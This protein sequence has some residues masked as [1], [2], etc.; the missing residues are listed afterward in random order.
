MSEKSA[1]PVDDNDRGTQNSNS[2]IDSVG[3]CIVCGQ[4]YVRRELST[5]SRCWDC[6]QRQSDE[7]TRRIEAERDA[8]ESGWAAFWRA[9]PRPES[10]HPFHLLQCMREARRAF[11][12]RQRQSSAGGD[13]T[14]PRGDARAR[15]RGLVDFV[16]KSTEGERNARLFWASCRAGELIAEGVVDERTV[17]AALQDAAADRGLS[18]SEYGDATRGTI[19]SGLRSGR[20]A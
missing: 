5:F 16:C 13:L 17:I 2:D 15:L 7:H 10:D 12:D 4:S 1:A 11:D 9:W 6:I 14:R 20:A 3:A 18:S 8:S 19:G